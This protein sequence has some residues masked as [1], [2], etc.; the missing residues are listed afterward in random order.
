MAVGDVVAT[1]AGRRGRGPYRE[2]HLLG[3]PRGDD[4]RLPRR[5]DVRRRGRGLSQ[6]IYHKYAPVGDGRRQR[7][8]YQCREAWQGSLLGN[9]PLYTPVEDDRWRCKRVDGGRRGSSLSLV[10]Y[11]QGSPVGD[12]RRRHGYC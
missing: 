11:H 4:R 7:G 2:I 9:V 8:R 1:D 3:A 10:M 12:G 5:A 6:K